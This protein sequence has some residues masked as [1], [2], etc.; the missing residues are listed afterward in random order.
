MVLTL[1]GAYNEYQIPNPLY[2]LQRQAE[3]KHLKQ[4]ELSLRNGEGGNPPQAVIFPCSL[5]RLKRR[6]IKVINSFFFLVME[7][8]KIRKMFWTL[9]GKR[10]SFFVF[11]KISKETASIAQ[12]GIVFGEFINSVI[13]LG[14]EA[15]PLCPERSCL[16][17]SVTP[18][19]ALER[20]ER[21]LSLPSFTSLPYP[22]GSDSNKMLLV[23]LCSWGKGQNATVLD[24]LRNY[25]T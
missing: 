5:T 22:L 23:G 8:N 12:K 14:G 9:K 11:L 18:D 7:P 25:K 20:L 4:G 19:T 6:H 10:K 17:C 21:V 16:D 2:F 15:S 13:N 3:G 24:I 1:L